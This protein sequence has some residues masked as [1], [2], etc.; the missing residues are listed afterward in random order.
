MHHRYEFS[1]QVSY[2]P[3]G[4]VHLVLGGMHNCEH[5]TDA[6]QS[7]LS[8]T[9]IE[10]LRI[11]FFFFAKTGYM[12]GVT[13]CPK[14]CSSDTPQDMCYCSCSESDITEDTAVSPF[15]LVACD[16]G[17]ILRPAIHMTILL[18]VHSY[19]C[20]AHVLLC[21]SVL[22]TI[23]MQA[24]IWD[25]LSVDLFLNDEGGYSPSTKQAVVQSICDSRLIP[26]D[27]SSAS[28]PADVAFWPM[29]PTLERL[30]Q[31]RKLK[32]PFKDEL[33]RNPAGNNMSVYCVNDNCKGHHGDDLVA[34][35]V[36]MIDQISNEYL[37]RDLGSLTLGELYTLMDPSKD[38]GM[39]LP[40]VYDSF[41]WDHC[42]DAGF[43]MARAPVGDWNDG[44]S[45]E[46]R[47]GATAITN[48]KR[49]ASA[50]TSSHASRRR[51]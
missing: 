19:L 29:H 24:D 31:W 34:F 41:D 49:N 8:A 38:E 1:W 9:D 28:S 15:P 43:D 30:W 4:P 42:M 27:A 32:N 37:V 12:T 35:S 21:N 44:W 3:H 47:Q 13:S 50:A 2:V 10:R 46:L 14:V 51:R 39:A 22:S 25:Q 48:I 11:G 16:P 23:L 5:Q 18:I 7:L 40:F 26:G 33:W 36:P 20:L 17:W 45:T 6:L